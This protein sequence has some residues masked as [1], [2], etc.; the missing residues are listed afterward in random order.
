MI[1]TGER[2]DY[3]ID[4]TA[5]RPHLGGLRWWFVCP[6]VVGGLAC[7][8]RAAKLYLGG[9]YFG[10]RACYDLTYTSCQESRKYDAMFAMLARE[11]G[12]PLAFVKRA[13]KHLG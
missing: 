9:L 12:Y 11:I 3:R 8:R 1:S 10:C 13:M 7:R 4:L 5:T 2:L 6:Q